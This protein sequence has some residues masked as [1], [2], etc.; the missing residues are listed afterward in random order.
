MLQGT[1]NPGAKV[2]A[3][4]Y[5][6]Y[7]AAAEAPC[8]GGSETALEP[9]AEVKAMPVSTAVV[10]LEPNMAY[11]FCLVASNAA[12]ETAVGNEVSFKT[13]LAPPAVDGQ[14]VSAV[15]ATGATLEAQVNPNNQEATYSFEYSTNATG[16]TLEGTITKVDGASALP[17]G[18]PDQTAAVTTRAVLHRPRPTSTALWRKTR[19]TNAPMATSHDSP[20]SRRRSPARSARSWQPPLRSTAA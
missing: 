9:E 10:G 20:L 11:V 17:V 5:F 14:Q 4:W 19:H 2:A 7:K 13:L 18:F 12:G 6:V 3:G 16:E 15:N 1:L 8:T